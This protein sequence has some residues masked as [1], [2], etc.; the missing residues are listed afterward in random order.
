MCYSFDKYITDSRQLLRDRQSLRHIVY[1]LDDDRSWFPP[2]QYAAADPDGLLAIGGDLSVERLVTA[3][4]RGIFPWYSEGQ[5]LLWWCPS[6]R[7][8][9][10][11]GEVRVNRSLGKFLARNPYKIKVNT[12]FPEVIFHCATVNRGEHNGTWITD[13]MMQAYINL[14]SKGLAHSIEVFEQNQLVGGLYGIDLGGVYCGESMFSLKPNASK[15]ALVYLSGYLKELGY[16]MIDC[17]MMN[18]YLEQMGAIEISRS[19]FLGRL[20]GSLVSSPI[21]HWPPP[22]LRSDRKA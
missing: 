17:Q 2:Y 22:N 6:S 15:C 10:I 21:N 19:D 18:P 20:Q 11:P 3:Y 12:C 9:I 1:E 5:P 16:Q 7:A 14:H 8:I 13:P 4:Q